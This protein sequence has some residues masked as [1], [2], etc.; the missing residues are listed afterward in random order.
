MD[1]FLLILGLILCLTGLI[2]SFT[3][4]I[5]GPLSSWLGI[6]IIHFTSYMPFNN[7]LIII[8]FLIAFIVFL[9]DI[10][11]PVIGLQK[12]GGSKNGL[13][14]ATIGLFIG[15]FIG[16]PFGLILGAFLGAFSGELIDKS[17]FKMALKPALGTFIGLAVGTALKFLI[18]TV[19][20]GIYFYKVYT[21]ILA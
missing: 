4:V 16:G 12:L 1:I 3:P 2:G 15:L 13:I 6:L 10:F 9:L 21:I 8:T 17:N 5:P 18:S 14:G 20:L 19:F 7:N 11:I